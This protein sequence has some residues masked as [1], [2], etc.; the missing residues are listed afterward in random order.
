MMTIMVLNANTV[1]WLMESLN[2]A[3]VQLVFFVKKQ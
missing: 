1:G 2:M 3:A